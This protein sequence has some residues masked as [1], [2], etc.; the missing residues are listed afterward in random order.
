MMKIYRQIIR[1]ENSAMT[2]LCQPDV[3]H[4]KQERDC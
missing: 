1:T 3:I 4:L 2:S